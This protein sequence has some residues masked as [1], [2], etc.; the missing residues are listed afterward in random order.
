MVSVTL[1]S[2]QISVTSFA[3]LETCAFIL[4]NMLKYQEREQQSRKKGTK[5]DS[6]EGGNEK[7]KKKGNKRKKQKKED[8]RN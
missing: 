7:G 5:E 6:K 1:M 3:T 2:K 4:L 8:V